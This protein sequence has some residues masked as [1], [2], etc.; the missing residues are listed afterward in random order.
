MTNFSEKY[1]TEICQKLKQ[2]FTYKSPFEIPRITQVTLNCG[3]GKIKE[4]DEEIAHIANDLALISSQKPRY[5]KSG[6][7]I[8][9]FKLRQGQVVGLSSTLR[10]KRM[11]D[12]IERLV[13]IA[14][15]RIRDFHG[16]NKKSFSGAGNYSIGIKEHTI[17][18]EIKFEK[19]KVSFGLQ[20]NISTTAKSNDQ[21][22]KLLE[23]FGFPFIK[24]SK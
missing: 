2:D 10:G 13:T 8:S 5:N 1:K 23:Y 19:T 15:P 6:K 20:V 7:S 17:F 24:E 3:I 9:G 12:F 21:A 4:S 16:L 22:Q 14:L 18:P 11:Y